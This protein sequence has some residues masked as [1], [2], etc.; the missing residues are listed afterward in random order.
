MVKPCGTNAAYNRHVVHKT[1]VCDACRKAHM[2]YRAEHRKRQYLNRGNLMMDGTGTVRRLQAL[3]RMGWRGKDIAEIAFPESGNGSRWVSA[4]MAQKTVQ[5]KT[6]WA[7]RRAYDQLSHL[8]GPSRETKKRALMKGFAP[9]L[10][11]DD[12]DD[13]KCRP[14]GF[15]RPSDYRKLKNGINS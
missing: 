7:V 3:M 11:W 4:V 15:L 8:P 6:Y 5:P 9:P 12:I 14:Q 10:A 2:E 1:P 13:P